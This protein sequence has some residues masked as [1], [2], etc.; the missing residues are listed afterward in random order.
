M[1][2]DIKR[3]S[4]LQRRHL[5]Q[6]AKI[7]PES[8]CSHTEQ[9]MDRHNRFSKISQWQRTMQI[10]IA[11]NTHDSQVDNE[12]GNAHDKHDAAQIQNETLIRGA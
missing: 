4:N 5:D 11:D 3:E 12:I 1:K 7:T 10:R 9:R 2:W 8:N 6:R